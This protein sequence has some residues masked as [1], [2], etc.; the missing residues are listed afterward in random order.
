MEK[1]LADLSFLKSDDVVSIARK[2]IGYKIST[3]FEGIITQAIITETE[4]YA[5]IKDKASHA[6][7]GR[8]T[9]RTKVM[10]GEPGLVYVYLCYGMH[11]LFNIVSGPSETPHAILIRGINPTLGI[12]QMEKRRNKNYTTKGFSSGPATSSQALGIQ[13]QHSGLVLNE[14]IINLLEPDAFIP[15]SEIQITPRIGIDYAEE[16]A[17]LPYRF[18]WNNPQRKTS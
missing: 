18:I 12:A 5:G 11:H 1:T 7:G 10:F 16:D 17:L 14:G 3:H 13:T 2:L 4:A 6:Y 8:K 15:E 9:E